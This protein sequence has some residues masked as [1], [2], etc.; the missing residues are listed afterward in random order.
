MD[1]ATTAVLAACIL[2]ILTIKDSIEWN[3]FFFFGITVKSTLS[4]VIPT[5]AGIAAGYV[6]SS[7]RS[8]SG[9]IPTPSRIAAD[10]YFSSVLSV[11]A[12]IS[13]TSGISTDCPF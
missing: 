9:V 8:V 6:Y 12:V 11:S 1:F 5:L 7:G 2:F 3:S 4:S 10:S 13:A